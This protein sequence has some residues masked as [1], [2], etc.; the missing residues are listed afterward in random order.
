MPLSRADDVTSRV[1]MSLSR[2]DDVTSRVRMSLSRADD[3][4]R[5][6]AFLA[7]VLL[8]LLHVAHGQEDVDTGKA[9]KLINIGLPNISR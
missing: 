3:T 1:R 2:A 4:C 9:F 7:V 5:H 8:L 6:L